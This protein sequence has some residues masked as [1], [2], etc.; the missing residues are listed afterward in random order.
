MGIRVYFIGEEIDGQFFSRLRSWS[1]GSY[2][3][4]YV[5]GFIVIFFWVKLDLE[6]VLVLVYV[7]LVIGRIIYIRW[8]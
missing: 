4:W 2:F 8:N 6:K 5:R 7:G 3:G 1:T